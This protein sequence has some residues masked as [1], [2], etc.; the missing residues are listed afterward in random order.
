MADITFLSLVTK[1]D[2]KKIADID[3]GGIKEDE[4][5]LFGTSKYDKKEVKFLGLEKMAARLV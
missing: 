2:F 4:L 3:A 5:K 1:D